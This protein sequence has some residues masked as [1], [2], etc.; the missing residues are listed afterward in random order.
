MLIC[1]DFMVSF[2]NTKQEEKNS[3]LVIFINAT[4]NK[5]EEKITLE[6]PLPINGLQNNFLEFYVPNDNENNVVIYSEN[7]V[8]LAEWDKE[9]F[10]LN[11]LFDLFN[12]TT[13]EE[14]NVG[15][16]EFIISKFNELVA[17][18]LKLINSWKNTTDKE[19]IINT[20]R[21][22]VLERKRQDVN[23]LKEQV[24]TLTTQIRDY[25]VAL[26]EK[27]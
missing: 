9:M 14:I 26:K 11:I 6:S 15:I 3:R 16:F 2:K 25:K 17:T 18:P 4:I 21:Q 1:I 12:E 13:S 24:R 10:E 23:S 5:T 19:V 8:P 22:N 20:I 27:I 7:N